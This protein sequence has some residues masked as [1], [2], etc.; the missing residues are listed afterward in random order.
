MC[1]RSTKEI[2]MGRAARVL[3]SVVLGGS[4]LAG[5][6]PATSSVQALNSVVTVDSGGDIGTYSSLT[7]D[8]AGNPVVSY[9]DDSNGDLKVAHCNDPNCAGGDDSIVTVDS[10]GDVGW[11]TSLL[12]DAAGN[13]VIAYYEETA[14]DLKVAHCNDPNCDGRDESIVTVDSTGDVGWSG[15]LALDASGNPVIS[16]NNYTS[17]DLKVAHCNDAD[18]AG[19]D[20]SIVIVDGGD[21]GWDTSLRLDAAGNP[22]IS[23]HANNHRDLKIAHCN[24]AN[25]AGADESI[26]TVD[27]TG[28]VGWYTSMVLD[29]AGSPVISYFDHTNGHLKVAH[30]NDANCAGQDDSI[31]TVD[32]VGVDAG[33]GSLGLDAAGNP[34]IGYHD[35]INGELKVAHCKDADCVSRDESV[36]VDS[37]GLGW[38]PS[39]VLDAAGNPAISYYDY[40]NGDLKVARCDRVSCGDVTPPTTSIELSPGTPDGANGWYL[41]PVTVTV[42]ATDDDAVLDTRCVLDPPGEPTSFDD[43]PDAPC[44]PLTVTAFGRH[45]VYASAIDA[46][47]NRGPVVHE[48][49]RSVGGLRCDG[50]VPTHIG[51]SRSDVLV[52]TSGRDVIVA[53]GGDDTVRGRGGDDTVCVGRGDNTVSAGPGHDHLFASGGNDTMFGGAGHDRLFGRAGADRLTGGIG[54]DRLVGGPGN[55]LL[56]ARAGNDLVFGGPGRDRIL[57]AAR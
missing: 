13:P 18:C 51:T 10:T 33:S 9:D 32:N 1:R 31:V 5:F 27:S 15:S 22:T 7:L 55:D 14:G 34:V 45:E 47:G 8:A 17:G 42:G 35:S 28:D 26:V 43:L 57:L 19:H 36:A 6:V 21:V 49:F 29:A 40:G 37:G 46:A 38:Y 23:Y 56:D 3:V 12:L 4:V 48:S 39:L 16:Y 41:S 52:G 50:R 44:T 2:V 53:F 25:C 30:C 20:E 11:H 54:D 24:D